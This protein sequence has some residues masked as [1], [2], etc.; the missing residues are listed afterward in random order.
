MNDMNMKNAILSFLMLWTI[1]AVAAP[2]QADPLAENLFA[3]ELMIQYQSEIGLTDEQREKLMSEMQSAQ[4]RF[5]GLHE[6]LQKEVEAM[7]VLLKK[8]PTDEPTALAQFDKV[9]D[10][11]REI[12][13]A[14]LGLVLRLK[15]KLKPEQVSKLREIKSKIA[16]GQLRPFEEVQRTLQ[17]KVQSVQEGVQRWQTDGRDPSPVVEIMQELEP[18][19]KAGKH[20]EAEAVLDRA[21]KVLGSAEKDK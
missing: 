2:P 4:E 10:R 12:K 11:E 1:G 18:L 14:H 21:L 15:G 3:P 13:R 20:K 6:R 16:S 19:M 17:T 9:L 7:A 5:A 8:E